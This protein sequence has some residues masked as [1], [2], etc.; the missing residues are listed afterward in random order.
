MIFENIIFSN[1]KA[2]FEREKRFN[3]GREFRFFIEKIFSNSGLSA[4]FG[5]N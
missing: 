2:C 4:G 3:Y 5:S 1:S